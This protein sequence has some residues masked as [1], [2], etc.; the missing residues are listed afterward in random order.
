MPCEPRLMRNF[1]K[2]LIQKK[3]SKFKVKDSEQKTLLLCNTATNIS[4]ALCFSSLQKYYADSGDVLVFVMKSRDAC[5]SFWRRCIEHHS[6][7]RVEEHR[8]RKG[9]PPRLLRKGSTYRYTCVLRR[10]KSSWVL[11]IFFSSHEQWHKNSTRLRWERN[12]ILQ[13]CFFNEIKVLYF[14]IFDCE[15]TLHF[16]HIVVCN[17]AP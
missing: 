16:Y 2:V 3:T 8:P 9:P 11:R 10:N 7:F 17:F 6:F 14:E 15:L 5:K 12:V 1:C 13:G 4:I